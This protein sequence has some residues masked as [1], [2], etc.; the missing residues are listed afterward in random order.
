VGVPR[1]GW[2]CA[3]ITLRRGGD[4]GSVPVPGANAMEPNARRD[5][6]VAWIFPLVAG[7]DFQESDGPESPRWR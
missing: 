7:R 1:V 4:A 2:N 5:E 3:E 6:G